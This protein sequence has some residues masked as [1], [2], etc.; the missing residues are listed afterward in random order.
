[1]SPAS[2]NLLSTDKREDEF[3]NHIGAAEDGCSGVGLVSVPDELNRAFPSIFPLACPPA[4]LNTDIQVD[5]LLED[6]F[7]DVA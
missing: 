2:S 7:S 3:R 6:H 4:C 1:M 5:E